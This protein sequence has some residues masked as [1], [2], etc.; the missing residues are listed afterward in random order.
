ME[1]GY[2]AVVVSISVT[3]WIHAEKTVREDQKIGPLFLAFQK[4]RQAKVWG[5]VSGVNS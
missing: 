4:S 3:D 2:S 1:V 5:Q